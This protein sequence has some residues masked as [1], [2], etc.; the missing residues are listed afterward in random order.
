M[1]LEPHWYS[2]IYGIYMIGSQ[3][4]SGFAFMILAARFLAR[5]G[6]LGEVIQPSHFHDWGK[7]MFAFVMLWAYFSY[8]QFL[9]TWAG[10]LPEEIQWYQH[11]LSHG[12]QFVAL[13]I[14]LFHFALPFS[15][16]LSRDLKRSGVRLGRVAALM[17]IMRW[18]DLVWQ[19]EPAFV[20]DHRPA[21]YWLYLAAPLALGGFW[22]WYLVRQLKARPLLPVNDPYLAD[23]FAPLREGKEALA[24]E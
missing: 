8:S 13:A 11:R 5:N 14:A 2:T 3:G 23:V 21:L 9:I 10:N 22:L 18:V 19:V 17:M 7:L 15:L 20:H 12:W 6:R 4:L 24:H 16:L 1:T